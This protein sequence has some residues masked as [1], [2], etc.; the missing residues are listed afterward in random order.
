MN[1]FE[2]SFNTEAR[3]AEMSDGQYTQSMEHFQSHAVD[4]NVYAGA[5]MHNPQASWG[6]SAVQNIATI[7]AISIRAFCERQAT[8]QLIA[9][10]STD[11]RMGRANVDIQSG[12]VMAAIEYL[13][14]NSTPNLLILECSGSAPDVVAKIDELA[15]FCDENV[16]VLVIGMTNDVQLYRELM[17]R[18]VAEYLVPPLETVQLVGSIAGLFAE[19]GTF[20]GRSI[21]V[22]GAKGGVGSSIIAHNLA[23]VMSC[24]DGLNCSI[25][26]LDLRFGT[27]ALHF[28]VELQNSIESAIMQGG[29]GD[30]AAADRYITNVND[31]LSIFAS[32]A[33]LEK[34]SDVAPENYQGLVDLVRKSVPYVV[35]DIPS[36]WEEWTQDVVLSADQ[37]VI[38]CEPE[39]ASL[40]NAKALVEKILLA[41]PNDAPPS[42]ILNK[43]GLPGR[44]EIPAK[45]FGNALGVAPKLT[46]P[47]HSE[48]FGKALNGGSMLSEIEPESP[49]NQAIVALASEITGKAPPLPPEKKSFFSQ[50]KSP[51]PR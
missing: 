14:S 17:K 30:D 27:S 28:N 16:Q 41:R 12:G 5:N 51:L 47:F 13:K 29:L 40:R 6:E 18:G 21:G 19:P 7:P 9:S 24:M 44:P 25:L 23:W 20:T 22:L 1:D 49:P 36:A 2:D 48:L 37:L 38:V 11:R 35:L 32:P 42:I 10:A 3:G 8:A 31:R 45:D 50:F 46:I 43:V 26:D 33:H 34:L 39:L 15:E 4:A